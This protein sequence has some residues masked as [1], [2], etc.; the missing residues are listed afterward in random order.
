MSEARSLLLSVLGD[1]ADD[2]VIDFVMGTVDDADT[3]IDEVVELLAAHAV[4]D[5]AEERLREV[6]SQVVTLATAQ[7]AVAIAPAAPLR[8]APAAAPPKAA[9]TSVAA[10]A[11]PAG[12]PQQ[13]RPRPLAQPEEV[14]RRSSD[15]SLTSASEDAAICALRELVPDASDSACRLVLRRS[16]GSV[17]EAAELL[18]STPVEE[19]EAAAADEEARGAQAAE[20]E[21]RADAATRR[22]VVSRYAQ[23]AQSEGPQTFEPPRLPYAQSRKEALKG[24]AV[25]YRDGQVTTTKGGGKFIVE[26]KEEWDGG[27]RGKVNNKGKRGPGFV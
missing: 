6:A 4:T 9:P 5:V 21:R 14:S 19:L 22:R 16:A 1:E 8:P 2:E 26:E 3:S 18:F 13:P 20:N 25:R 15:G 17:D 27:S 23:V 11:R 10:A 24:Q 12:L 7:P